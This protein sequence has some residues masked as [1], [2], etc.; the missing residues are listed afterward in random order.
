MILTAYLKAQSFG[1]KATLRLHNVSNNAKEGVFG[2]A[3]CKQ[4][5]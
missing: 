3:H 5:V 1:L 4:F 2:Q